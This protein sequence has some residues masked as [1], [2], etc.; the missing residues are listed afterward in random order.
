MHHFC[1]QEVVFCKDLVVILDK[2][3]LDRKYHVTF[4]I[5]PSTP[6][7]GE[8]GYMKGGKVIDLQKPGSLESLNSSQNNNEKRRNNRNSSV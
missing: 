6:S 2:L 8:G 4:T 5:K 3:D 1:C 7:G